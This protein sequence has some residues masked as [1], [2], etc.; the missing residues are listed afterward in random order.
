VSVGDELGRAAKRGDF[1]AVDDML[2]GLDTAG[3][4]DARAWYRAARVELARRADASWGRDESETRS[5]HACRQLAA[6]ALAPGPQKAAAWF[7]LK[8]YAAWGESG[9]AVVVA[10][11]AAM[12]RDWCAAFLEAA[13]RQRFTGDSE[14]E[15]AR[16]ALFGAPLLGH[17]RLRLPT[18]SAYAQGW[19]QHH[20]RLMT[21]SWWQRELDRRYAEGTAKHRQPPTST[22]LVWFDD[23]GRVQSRKVLVADL[24]LVEVLR[25][26]PLVAESLSAATAMPGALGSFSANPA[27]GWRL[28]EAVR[29]LVSEGRLDRTRIIDDTLEALTRQDTPGTQKALAALLLGA[30]LGAEDVRDRVPLLQGLMAT[31]QGAVTAVL[32]PL[33]L[34]CVAHESDMAELAVTVF[35]RK[36]KRLKSELVRALSAK[37][38]GSR[39][40]RDSVVAG[41]LP[42]VD[43]DDE[44]LAARARRALESLGADVGAPPVA[45]GAAGDRGLWQAH[46]AP[47]GVEP[48]ELIEP[49][50]AGLAAAV[51]AAAVRSRVADDARFLDVLVRWAW[52]D[53]DGLRRHLVRAFEPHGW[54]QPLVVNLAREWATGALTS[55]THA[56]ERAKIGFLHSG[57]RIPRAMEDWSYSSLPTTAAFARLHVGETLLGLGTVP[58]LLSTPTD[59]RGVLAFD[60]LRAALAAQGAAGCG[61]LDLFQA[62]LR[63]EPVDP[64]RLREL[65]GLS[66][67]IRGNR[68]GRALRS[69]LRRRDGSA[70]TNAVD[71]VRQWVEGGGLPSLEAE[72]REDGLHLRPGVPPVPGAVFPAVPRGLTAGHDPARERD[73]YPWNITPAN[74]VGVVPQWPDVVAAKTLPLFDQASK[75]PPR[76]LPW[77]VSTAGQ[78]GLPLHHAL[79]A[80]LSHEDESSRLQAVDASLVLMAQG[81]FDPAL[82]EQVCVRLLDGGSLRLARTAS[83]WEQVILGGGLSLLWPALA[84][85]ADRACGLDRKPA[86]LAD[87]LAMA[88]RYAA[89]VP[90]GATPGSVPGGVARLAGTKGGSKAAV[91]A[92]AW[93][94]AQPV[95]VAT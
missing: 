88:R 6:V 10:R 55:A 28:E 43:L 42:A 66:V 41:L 64:G 12:G 67:P 71:V 22:T 17:F 46:L 72:Y 52:E 32:F 31:T 63:L 16:L 76:W 4:K 3:L 57:E 73:T 92:R 94:R 65:D 7:G 79:A 69:L 74:S 61:E 19:A 21:M 80:T 53:R 68:A 50:P 83:A 78:A 11:M 58:C 9:R 25:L 90:A 85:V 86:G 49:T 62:L 60:G 54:S 37:D 39:F 77:L 27:D 48:F 89:S 82:F 81:R 70:G 56:R 5:L 44:S 36:E 84:S 13:S 26:D 24:T 1:Q 14:S 29:T 40:G 30:D 20:R 95:G 47:V 18:G 87:L 8:S 59:E 23:A 91:E 93:V 45:A 15:S 2:G 34:E 33:V 51:S 35:A 75:E 38:S